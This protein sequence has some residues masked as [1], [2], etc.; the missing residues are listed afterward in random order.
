VYEK[1]QFYHPFP[2][3]VQKAEFTPWSEGDYL[4]TYWPDYCIKQ[5]DW[6]QA[7]LRDPYNMEIINNKNFVDAAKTLG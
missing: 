5:H 3:H 6:I 2:I 4:L 1:S 7:N